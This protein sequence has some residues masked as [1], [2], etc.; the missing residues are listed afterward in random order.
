MATKPS[1]EITVRDY[2]EEIYGRC[3]TGQIIFVDQVDGH[4]RVSGKFDVND[5]DA[6]AE[7]VRQYPLELYVKVNPMDY[8]KI[9]DRNSSG[10]GGVKEITEIIGFHYDV[11]AGK[12]GKYLTA[13]EMLAALD[14]MPVPP[15]AIVLSNGQ[16]GGFHA[17]WWLERPIVIESEEQRTDLQGI[18]N[19]WLEELREHAKPGSVDGTANL[20]RLLRPIGSTRKSGNT[21]QALRWNPNQRYALDDFRLAP[22]STVAESSYQPA[23]DSDKVID[24]YLTAVGENDPA[25]LLERYAS[26]SRSGRFMTRPGGQSGSPTCE[27]F[28]VNG[29]TGATFKSGACEPFTALNKS[30]TNGNWYS[31]AAIYVM[32]NH[33]DNW[34]AAAAHC[35]RYFDRQRGPS[36]ILPID[37]ANVNS[38]REEKAT[39]E[40]ATVPDPVTSPAGRLLNQYI[41]QINEGELPQLIRQPPPFDGIEVGAGLIT[42]IGAPP[43]FGKTALAMQLMFDALELDDS[44]RAVVANAET[45]FDGLLR[46][47]LTRATRI[48]S[49]AIRFGKLTSHELERIN[50]AASDLIPRLQRVSVLNDPCNVIQLY[51]L[52]GEPPGLLIVD[53][54]QKFAPADKDPRQGVNEVVATL[55]S[56]S[57][58]GWAVLCLSATKRDTNGKHNSKELGLSSFRE[59]GEIEYNADSAYVM[60]DNGEIGAKYI[61]HITLTHVKNRHGS[62]DDRQ[63]Q[64]H[65]PRMSFDAFPVQEPE[66]YP[67]FGSVVDVG[68]PFYSEAS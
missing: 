1:K 34:K 36:D 9:K 48:D 47:E 6:A 67:E 18:S 61:R 10:I 27:L 53:Y 40:V 5:L 44:L 55:R 57:K 7:H 45:S 29:R 16:T 58:L 26:Y 15:S 51:K 33:G 14:A 60:V 8:R 46:R 59:S 30:G 43:G 12:N 68:D 19:R 50:E 63:L 66:G 25:F 32:L 41:Q 17:Y 62:K 31:T 52:R 23:S 42:I 3:T 22:L 21:V 4:K 38:G 64:F 2:L 11:D 28:E 49:N 39:S 54:L 24:E 56:L 35:H 65:M 20:D 13:E 37:Y